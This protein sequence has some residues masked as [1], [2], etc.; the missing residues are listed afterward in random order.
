MNL[1]E[2]DDLIDEDEDKPGFH[3][4]KFPGYPTVYCPTAAMFAYV[5]LSFMAILGIFGIISFCKN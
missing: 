1:Q 5:F 2:L 3:Q 4:K